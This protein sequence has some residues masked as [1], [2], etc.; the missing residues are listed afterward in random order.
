MHTCAATDTMNIYVYP[1]NVDTRYF[2]QQ[3]R[4]SI[5][6]SES[7]RSTRFVEANLP[8]SLTLAQIP[9]RCD[10]NHRIV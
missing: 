10:L 2:Y 1:M 4:L 7:G 5:F 8:S 6:H 3:N 9:T